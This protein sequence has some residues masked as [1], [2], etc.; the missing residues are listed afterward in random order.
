[1]SSLKKLHILVIDDNEM[2]R[3]VLRAILHSEETYD[4][5]GEATN[6][7]SGLELAL[8]LRPDIICLDVIM[9]K[10]DG[11]EVLAQIKEKLPQVLVLMVTA[12]N[13]RSTVQTA[14][15]HGAAGFIIKPF[16]AGTVLKTMEQAAAKYRALKQ[17]APP[18]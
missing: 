5:I 9:P 13:D 10:T 17:E 6:G 14:V 11:L 7:E 15:Q 3:A 4:V 18:S 1:M 12:N 16:S 2:T 8:K